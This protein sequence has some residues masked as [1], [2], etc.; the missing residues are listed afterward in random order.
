VALR[1]DPLLRDGY[2]VLFVDSFRSRGLTQICT[3]RHVNRTVKLA[4]RR[5]DGRAVARMIV[6]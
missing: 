3:T 2:A 1:A 5:L 6:C 4:Q